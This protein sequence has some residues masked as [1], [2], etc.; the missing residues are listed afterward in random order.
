ICCYCGPIAKGEEAIRPLRSFGPPLQDM[1]GPMPYTVQ[2]CLTDAAFPAGSYYYNKGGSLP[3]LTDQAIEVFVEYVAKKPSPLSAV[4]IQTV[5]GVASR[6]D[7]Q[8]TAFAH[9]RLPYA[10]VK[11]S[12]WLD[13]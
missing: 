2:Q 7:A 5:C 12:Q 6:V 13:A 11:V 10:P 1:L 4:A 3:D 8:T 9:R